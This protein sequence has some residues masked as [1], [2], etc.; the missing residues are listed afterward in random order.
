MA[1][2]LILSN[3][4]PLQHHSHSNYASPPL[5]SPPLPSPPL[6]S[7]P[8]PSPPL[9]SPPLPS[10]CGHCCS[11]RDLNIGCSVTADG[12]M[13][14]S[15]TGDHRLEMQVANLHI[16][17]GCDPV[18]GVS[19]PH[20]TPGTHNISCHGLLSHRSIHSSSE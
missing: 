12:V 16:L 8:L 7:P 17:G 6:P 20:A 18:V 11:A 3:W 9:P 4:W 15:N 19:L 10:H 14:E 5:P 1:P 13:V 2:Q